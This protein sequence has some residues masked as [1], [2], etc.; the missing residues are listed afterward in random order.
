MPEKEKKK[1][2]VEFTKELIRF[3][4]SSICG[5]SESVKSLAEIE[6]KFEDDYKKLKEIK[7]D[8]D[9]IDE[10][11][12]DMSDKEKEILLL[13]FTKASIYGRK[14]N[15]LFDL[16]LEDKKK[17]AKDLNDF[18]SF[19]ETKLTELTEIQKDD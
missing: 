18:A 14:L 19:V 13:V 4:K 17:L 8:P 1:F 5:S 12:K 16:S 11:M 7:M 2:N 10:I 15:G 9:Q 3:L 6:E